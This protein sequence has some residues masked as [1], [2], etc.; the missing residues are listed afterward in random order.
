MYFG[1]I[2]IVNSGS[3]SEIRGKQHPL[4]TF[5][6]VAS[7]VITAVHSRTGAGSR[8]NGN[9]RNRIMN[10]CLFPV[11]IAHNPK[12]FFIRQRQLPPPRYCSS[13]KLLESHI[14]SHGKLRQFPQHF[15]LSD[16]GQQNQNHRFT[17]TGKYD[18]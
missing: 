6:P 13:P 2:L 1:D 18:P 10:K 5:S 15:V 7:F 14:D 11:P 4:P 8:R 3:T 17:L 12:V 9:Q 16:F